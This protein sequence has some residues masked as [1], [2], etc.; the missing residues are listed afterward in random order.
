MR[1]MINRDDNSLAFL[2]TS[3]NLIHPSMFQE[4]SIFM[5]EFDGACLSN[6]PEDEYLNL[7]WSPESEI[8]YLHP[9]KFS[10]S[11]PSG[12]LKM[13]ELTQAIALVPP[14][15]R[16][17]AQQNDI[18]MAVYALGADE[19]EVILT[20]GVLEDAEIAAILGALDGG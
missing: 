6:V 1:A 2:E 11:T 18:A 3:V 16:T 8:L 7:F 14:E 15:S 13:R 4:P 10:L 5:V 12:K 19:V 17:D 9:E 20:D